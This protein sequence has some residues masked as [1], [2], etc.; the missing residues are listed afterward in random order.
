MYACR[1]T[2]VDDAD[3]PS[4]EIDEQQLVTMVRDRDDVR[5]RRGGEFGDAAD[6]LAGRDRGPRLAAR[7]AYLEAFA[8]VLVADAN[9]A[10]P[11]AEPF[12]FAITHAAAG[13]VLDNG[14]FP[15]R[16]REW[17]AARNERERGAVGTGRKT[18]EIC[19]DF[20]EAARGLRRCR[21][22]LDGNERAAAARH[23][24]AM[25]LRSRGIDDRSAVGR[26]KANEVFGLVRVSAQIAAV[27]FDRIDISDPLVVGEE[28]DAV[29]DPHRPAEIA[30]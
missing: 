14:F 27:G 26:R 12:G 3:V 11:V 19:G 7:V 25:D 1:R 2:L 4:L 9:E 15:E 30:F 28:V 24:E 6:V 13:A 21:R 29:A 8:A 18:L 17:S 22:R 5:S 16:H 10:L 23:V 20:N